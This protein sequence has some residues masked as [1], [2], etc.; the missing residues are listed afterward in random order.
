M[1]IPARF[2]APFLAYARLRQVPVSRIPEMEDCPEPL[3]ADR[4]TVMPVA[5]FLA[6]LSAIAAYLPEEDLGLQVGRGMELA[7][8][9]IVYQLSLKTTS[10]REALHY[11]H[12][13]LRQSLPFAQIALQ[14]LPAFIEIRIE[15]ENP[16]LQR[17]LADFVATLVARELNV[18]TGHAERITVEAIGPGAY[19]IHFDAAYLPGKPRQ[20]KGFETL[21]PAY[22]Q[23]LEALQTDHSFTSRVKQMVLSMASPLLPDLAQTAAAFHLTPRTLQRRLR[24][25]GGSFAAVREHLK[26]C[27]CDLLLRHHGYDLL[28]VSLLLGYAEPASFYHAYKKW[29]GCSPAHKK[30]MFIPKGAINAGTA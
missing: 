1:Q 3:L 23:L 22:L 7:H 14:E 4:F 20:Y 9:G 10:L 27:L 2:L 6:V 12:D 15:L 11:C 24:H 28:D 8:I 5:Q 18:L 26:R 17:V 16:R 25:E 30:R 21:L 19:R 13:Y 29:Y